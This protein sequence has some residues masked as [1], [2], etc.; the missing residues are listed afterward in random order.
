MKNEIKE[1]VLTKLSLLGKLSLGEVVSDFHMSESTA[2]R[3][4][5]EL[6]KEGSVIRVHGGIRAIDSGLTLYSFEQGEKTNMEKKTAI[7]KASISLLQDGD[8]IFCDSGT[9]IRCFCAELVKCTSIHVKVYTNSLANFEILKQY[10]P[11]TLIGGEYRANRKDFCGYIGE[12]ALTSLY[13]SKCFVGADGWTG[14]GFSTTDFE[15]ARINETAMKNSEKV[16]L[17][18]DSSKF[19]LSAHVAYAPLRDLSGIITDS[20]IPEKA[21]KII[22]KAG[23]SLKKGK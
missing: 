10:M 17:L 19:S 14:N 7:A 1:E 8:V 4:F 22:K 9:T 6:E 11:V 3:L 23:V 12:Q 16:Y 20:D 21:E 15:T 18:T 13:F 5:A 2:R